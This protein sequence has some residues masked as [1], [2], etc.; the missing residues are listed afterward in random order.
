MRF[1]SMY[2]TPLQAF[3]LS[4]FHRQHLALSTRTICQLPE[5]SSH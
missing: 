2:G 5:F 4:Y 1:P 3:S